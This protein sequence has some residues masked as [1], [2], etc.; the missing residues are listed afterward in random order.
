MNATAN[1]ILAGV[2]DAILRGF[3]EAGEDSTAVN[4]G[5]RVSFHWPPHSVSRDY[6]V[7]QECW[8]DESEHEI[9]GEKYMVQWATTEHGVFGRIIDL[10]NEAKGESREEVL[11]L[12]LEGATPWFDRMDAISNSIGS[13]NRF[14]GQIV[15]LA[16][17]DIAKL[18]FCSDRDVASAAVVEIEKRASTAEFLPSFIAIL[19]D[20]LHPYRR[21]AQWCVLDMLEDYSAF[22]KTDAEVKEAVDAIEFLMSTT[23]DDHARAIYKAGVVLGGHFCNEPAANA[24]INCLT[25]PSKVGRRSAMHA[26]FHLVEWLPAERTRVIAALEAAAQQESEPLLKEFALS[27]ARD[28]S[29]GASDHMEEPVFAEEISA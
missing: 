29:S 1:E 8:R 12:L 2:N 21:T 10:W 16:S 27:Q 26:V 9:R 19:R 14:H 22:C 11:S 18:L 28:I 5:H 7:T 4:P 17:P 3:K 23:H 13:P 24:L 6:H 25:A 20:G 15:D